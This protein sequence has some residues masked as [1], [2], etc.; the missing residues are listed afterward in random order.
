[1]SEPI[2]LPN[3]RGVE[4]AVLSVIMQQPERF[5]ELSTL[6]DEH[7]YVPAHQIIFGAIKATLNEN[8][9][10][11]LVTFVERLR[12]NGFLEICGGAGEIAG[13]NSFSNPSVRLDNH[14]Q[15]LNEMLARRIAINKS[16]ALIEASRNEEID[17]VVELADSCASEIESTLNSAAEVKTLKSILRESF[18]KFQDRATGKTDSIGIPS[19]YLIDRYLRG[20]HGGRLWVIGAYPSGGKSILA[21]QIVLEVIKRGNPAAYISLEMQERDIMDRML[22]QAS[23]IVASAFTE[24]VMYAQANGNETLQKSVTDALK[25]A[26]LKLNDSPLQIFKSP[27]NRLR[28]ILGLIRKTVRENKSKVVVIDYVQLIQVE[29]S[30]TEAKLSEISHALQHIAGELDISILILTQLNAE[31]ET[32]HGRVIEEDADAFLSIVQDRNKE[33][34]TY[35]MHRHILI[36]KDRHYG[37]SGERIKLVFNKEKIVFLEGEDETKV[38]KET[39][40]PAFKRY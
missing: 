10:L 24:P 11:E 8:K 36:A 40:K 15:I 28:T 29:A 2:E 9:E 32:K 33:S 3:S 27:N 35:K 21:S 37:T 26:V 1:M 13:L 18:N 7:F 34:E 5:D 12:A 4:K 39:K 23:G 20:L 17:Q 30:N 19:L 14:C 16:E 22:V 6:R 38:N 25:M 31:G